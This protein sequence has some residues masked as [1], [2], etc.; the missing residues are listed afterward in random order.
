MMLKITGINYTLLYIHIEKWIFLIIIIFQNFYCIS[1]QINTTT[2]SRRDLKFSTWS[3]NETPDT[4]TPHHRRRNTTELPG[5]FDSDLYFQ[6][7]LSSGK[8]LIFS[9][10]SRKPIDEEREAFLSFSALK[11]HNPLQHHTIKH[12]HCIQTSS[13]SSESHDALK[14]RVYRLYPCVFRIS[15]WKGWSPWCS[16]VVA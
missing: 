7:V 8:A 13:A 3:V 6:A 4:H 11:D 15:V 14:H 1:D 16:A 5:V 12:T 10:Q 9:R 2:V